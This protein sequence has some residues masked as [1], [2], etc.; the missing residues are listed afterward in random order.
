MAAGA[1]VVAKDVCSVLEHSNHK[2]AVKELDAD[3]RG[4]SKVYTLGGVQ[5]A[6]VISESGPE[7]SFQLRRIWWVA[8]AN[9]LK[10]GP[11]GA[12]P[13]RLFYV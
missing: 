13:E 3:E 5:E 12:V 10:S 9:L 7:S 2:M 4:G 8:F 1:W 11:S 6:T